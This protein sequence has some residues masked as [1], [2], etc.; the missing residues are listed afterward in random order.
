MGWLSRSRHL[1]EGARECRVHGLLLFTGVDANL[2][3]GQPAAA[4]DAARQIRDLGG[5]LNEPRLLAAGLNG[6]GRALINRARS[7]TA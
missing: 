3:A 6:E 7:Q 5:R 2:V 1:L 4:V